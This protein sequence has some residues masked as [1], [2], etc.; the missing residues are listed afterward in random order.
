M[1]MCLDPGAI[2]AGVFGSTATASQGGST[3]AAAAAAAGETQE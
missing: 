1:A 2:A 3:A